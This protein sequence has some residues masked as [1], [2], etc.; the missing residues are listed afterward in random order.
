MTINQIWTQNG[1][2]VVDSSGKPFYYDC[3][4][5]PCDESDST[6]TPC[7]DPFYSPP[8]SA[9][10]HLTLSYSGINNGSCP[11]SLP[12]PPGWTTC[13]DVFL[14]D[15]Y[16]CWA[17]NG[18]QQGNQP[19]VPPYCTS[20]N[21]SWDLE[22]QVVDS[23]YWPCYWAAQHNVAPF[24]LG[25]AAIPWYSYSILQFIE[26]ELEWKVALTLNFFSGSYI[27]ESDALMTTSAPDC[28]AINTVTLGASNLRP[29]G[30][31]QSMG[32]G[33]PCDT[34]ESASVEEGGSII[35]TITGW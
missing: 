35:A 15:E 29:F 13:D 6:C 31:Y 7:Y 11:G 25:S 17:V 1:N 24:V 33:C 23:L 22:L 10:R 4:N 21:R 12:N 5:C 32:W 26:Y 28:S 18:G 34:G 8:R 30:T 14:A 16:L 27:W 20:M 2:I 19:R 9:Q 3:D